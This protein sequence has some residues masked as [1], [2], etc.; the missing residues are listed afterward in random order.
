MQVH[1]PQVGWQMIIM[2]THQRALNLMRSQDKQTKT[3]YVRVKA[4]QNHRK[5]IQHKT[6]F[7]GADTFP[8]Y[9][10]LVP[11]LWAF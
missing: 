1:G 5:Q 10:A 4:Q 7:K 8:G 9:I 3:E 11:R 2:G 6:S